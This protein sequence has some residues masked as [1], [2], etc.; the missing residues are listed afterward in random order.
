L[1]PGGWRCTFTST[2]VARSQLRASSTRQQSPVTSHGLMHLSQWCTAP[3]S[4]NI[5]QPPQNT[6][7]NNHSRQTHSHQPPTMRHKSTARS[8]VALAYR[9]KE[10]NASADTKVSNIHTCKITQLLTEPRTP[11]P[12]RPTRPK[13]GLRT[14]SSPSLLRLPPTAR[15]RARS[16]ASPFASRT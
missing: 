5:F 1:S 8:T 13:A 3:P 6:K 15:S 11:P 2:D 16:P 9:G 12:L 10:A 7:L 4:S 14:S